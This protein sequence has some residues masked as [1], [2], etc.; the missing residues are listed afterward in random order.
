VITPAIALL[1]ACTHET[2]DAPAI[3]TPLGAERLAR[4]VSVDLRGVVPSTEELDEAKDGGLDTL[5]DRWLEDPRFEEHL[6]DVFAESWLLR[7]DE[8]QVDADEFDLADDQQYAMTRAFGDEPARLM[9]H[10]AATDAPWTDIVTTD[11]TMANDLMAQLVPIEFTNPDDTGEWREARYTD[12]RPAGGVVMTSGLWLRY[13]TTLF[14]Y[15]RGRAAMIG[16]YLLCY[17]FFER[18]VLLSETIDETS[19][20]GLAEATQT[21]PECVAC[22]ATLDPLASSLF[23]FYPF[24]DRDG[25]ELVTYHPERERLGAS[26]IGTEPGYFGTPIHGAAELGPLIA[27]DPRFEMCAVKRAAQQLWGRTVDDTD[28]PELLALRDD[29]RAGDFRYKALLRGILA[30]DEYRAGAFASGATDADVARLRPVRLLSPNTLADVVEDLTGYRWDLDGADLL[31]SDTDGYRLLL[32]GADGLTIRTSVLEPSVSRALTIRRLAQAAAA[33]VVAHDLAAS[34]S[35]R[36]LV[37]TTI[38]DLSTAT[39]GSSVFDAELTAIHR[40]V[41]G[42][43]PTEDQR[44]A[45]NALWASVN[46]S[47]GSQQ[48]WASL[49]SVLL[50]D[51]EFWSY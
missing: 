29:L 27:S 37:G 5:I 12:G 16:R 26:Y 11:R 28:L 8:L 49:V 43:E 6:T 51:P 1:L 45:E 23:G 20:E 36:R 25:R 30:S 15:N 47:A 34:R 19:T 13:A 48:A 41:L 9:A 2:P 39:P 14:N 35:D 32:G 46:A 42:E 31:D 22:H 24:E 38:D 33:T 21:V 4:R 18:P 10:V 17:D 50:R 44:S 7:A 40:R 3:V